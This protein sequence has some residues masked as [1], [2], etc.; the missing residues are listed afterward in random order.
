MAAEGL[1]VLISLWI[2]ACFSSLSFAKISS[3][4]VVLSL[5]R[6]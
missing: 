5:R 3:S 6:E 4:P 2:F 1:K